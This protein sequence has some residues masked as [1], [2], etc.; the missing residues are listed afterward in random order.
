M[1]LKMTRECLQ[2]KCERKFSKK[3]TTKMQ[4]GKCAKIARKLKSQ[5]IFKNF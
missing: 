4:G 1:N 2:K 3:K 5:T